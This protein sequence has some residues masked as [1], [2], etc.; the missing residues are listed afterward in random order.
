MNDVIFCNSF[1]FLSH[2]F[3]DYRFTDMTQGTTCYHIGYLKFGH[4]GFISDGEKHE[5]R[6]GDVFFIPCGC[7]YR[8]YWYGGADGRIVFDSYAFTYMPLHATDTFKLQKLTVS[9]TARAYIDALSADKRVSPRSVGMLYAFL[10]EVMDSMEKDE[11]DK[12]HA[13][14]AKARGYMHSH[15]GYSVGEVAR[16]CNVSESA[17]YAAFREA[18]GHT[19][20][21]EKHII[22]AEKAVHLLI[23]TDMSVEEISGRLS[24]SSPSYMRKILKAKTGKTPREIRK[25]PAI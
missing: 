11:T 16:Y 6:E 8:S 4:A 14:L 22:Q 2:R 10:G 17:L 12:I 15:N 1:A 3:T 7:K 23:T 20:I 9:D 24:F 18:A 21:D 5:F 19:P 13:I 25:E